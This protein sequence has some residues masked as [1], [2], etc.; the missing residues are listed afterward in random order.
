MRPAQAL[1]HDLR[2]VLCQGQRPLR[3]E[4]PFEKQGL[5]R[6]EKSDDWGDV[7]VAVMS[8]DGDGVYPAYIRRENGTGRVA[9]LRIVY[10]E[11]PP[12]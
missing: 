3:V 7:G 8:G 10:V 6:F 5:A 2:I 11:E 4:Q 9:E 12:A 1:E